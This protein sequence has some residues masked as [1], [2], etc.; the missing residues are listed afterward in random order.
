MSALLGARLR[1]RV[2]FD[3]L[4]VATR[5]SN[6]NLVRDWEPVAA[7]QNVP[8]EVLTGPGKESTPAAQP[9]STIAARVTLRYQSDLADPYGMRVRFGAVAYHVETHYFDVTGRQWVTLVCSAG[10]KH[11]S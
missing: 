10:A 7:L 3:V 5:D 4:G 11:V 8:A 2:S 1:H 6:G 9:V